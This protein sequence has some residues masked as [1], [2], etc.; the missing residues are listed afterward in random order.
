MI[1]KVVCAYPVCSTKTYVYNRFLHSLQTQ[2]WPQ[3]H[4]I[5]LEIHGF[6]D[7]PLDSI[8]R[9]IKLDNHILH[10]VVDAARNQWG[11]H[12]PTH[13]KFVRVAAMQA[14]IFQWAEYVAE[15]DWLWYVE[16]DQPQPPKTLW[17]LLRDSL[18]PRRQALF[19]ASACSGNSLG[20]NATGLDGKP[21]RYEQ[22][23]PA[24]RI[25]TAQASSMGSV[26]FNLHNMPKVQ[27]SDFPDYHSQ[28]GKANDWFVCSHLDSVDIDTAARVPHVRRVPD[29]R[30]FENAILVDNAGYLQGCTYEVAVDLF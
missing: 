12:A 7:G 20:L 18:V 14:E 15:A 13:D 21:L 16:V 29:G 26:L 11:E 25:I 1:D 19:A 22:N 28:T 2:V 30:L 10:P 24:D 5:E 3:E 4:P 23:I 9:T 6:V 8:T 17:T 27:W